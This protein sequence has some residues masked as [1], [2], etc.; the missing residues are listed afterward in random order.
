MSIQV[1]FL[2]IILNLR[3]QWNVN[4]KLSMFLYTFFVKM[5]TFFCTNIIWFYDFAIMNI[6]YNKAN[7]FVHSDSLNR[8]IELTH[9]SLFVD[10][11]TVFSFYIIWGK[12]LTQ[13][14]VIC[15][16]NKLSFCLIGTQSSAYPALIQVC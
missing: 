7:C 5:K 14:N 15:K 4:W 9:S 11:L 2:E 12:L 8:V 1:L 10:S 3:I 13:T 6:R 16:V